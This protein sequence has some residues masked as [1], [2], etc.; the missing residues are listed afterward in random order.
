MQDIMIFLIE[1]SD[2]I[3]ALIA[4]IVVSMLYSLVIKKI[5]HNLR[6]R[7]LELK[8]AII[9]NRSSE[10]ENTVKEAITRIP[11]GVNEDEFFERLKKELLEI[12]YIQLQDDNEISE[13]NSLYKFLESHHRQ[14]L[15]Q[16]SVQF[17]FSI[18]AA[19]IG[20]IF[21]IV[22]ICT[23]TGSEWYEIIVKVLPGAIIDA[24]SVL[25][26]NQAHETRDRAA[27]FFKELTYDKQVAKSVAIA[28]A[29]EDKAIKATVQARIAL[30]IAGLKDEEIKKE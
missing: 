11:E 27:D 18:F 9:E 17:W 15:Q 28:D 29:I 6:M 3:T 8:S 16:S 12:S 24:I 26:F 7:E 25:F 1:N 4:A 13:D 20:F 14:A 2:M 21:I 19:S 30:H 10:S 5:N 23:S 22:M